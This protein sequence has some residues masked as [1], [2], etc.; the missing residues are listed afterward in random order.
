MNR[1][2]SRLAALLLILPGLSPHLSAAPTQVHRLPLGNDGSAVEVTSVFSHAPPSG[3]LPLRVKVVNNSAGNASVKIQTSSRSAERFREGQEVEAGFSVEAP[4]GKTTEREFLAPLAVAGFTG[5]YGGTGNVRL[6]IQHGN[7]TSTDMVQTGGFEEKPFLVLSEALAGKS[8]DDINR[9]ATAITS[10][11]SGGYRSG[12]EA[13]AALFSAPLLP[14]DWRGYSGVDQLGVSG[15]EWSGLQP[16]VKA[17][18][19][20][21]VKMG[22]HLKV[23]LKPNSPSLAERGITGTEANGALGRGHV[24]G[25]LWDGDYLAKWDLPAGPIVAKRIESRD[26][27]RET[28]KKAA[29]HGI[30]DRTPL[31]KAL[32]EKSFA[33]W[34]VGIILF[35]FGIVVGPVN[36]FYFARSGRRHRLFFT[37][38]VISLSATAI[39]LL[40][41][42][43]QDGVGGAGHRASVVYLDAAEKNAFIH[44]F[45]VSRT[46]VL[47]G[48]SFNQEEPAVVTMALMPPSRWTR[49]KVS[50]DYSYSSYGRGDSQKYTVSDRQYSG[51]WFQSR[52]EQAQI[53]DAVQSTRGRLELKPG[54]GAPVLVSS[55]PGTL[56]RVWYVAGENEFWASS[57]EV[58]TGASITMTKAGKDEFL[59]WRK[60]AVSLLPGDSR[61]ELTREPQPGFFYADSLDPAVGAVDTLGSIDW[62][63]SRVFLYGPLAH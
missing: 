5:G 6:T 61:Y 36:L 59:K 49:L 50:E 24:Q 48:G 45:Q 9:S 7:A 43:F 62:K 18:I 57:G 31:I 20:Q 27:L 21:W 63:S 39:L 8:I 32:G 47:F 46:G 30:D 54:T 33:A 4:A 53:I 35:V 15:D 42:F 10:S 26:T 17:A 19:L 22:G 2:L 11:S 52:T 40:M 12:N 58:A 44:Q 28:G 38:P 23:F 13:F 51:D 14:A 60:E 37:T 29:G 56:A 34:Q 41:I 55:L 1:S 25:V 16:G 3:Y